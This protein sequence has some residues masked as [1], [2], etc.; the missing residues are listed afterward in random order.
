MTTPI[1]ATTRSL[2]HPSAPLREYYRDNIN[3]YFT[4][5]TCELS[6]SRE[7]QCVHSI[8]A[9]DRVFIPEQFATNHSRTRFVSGSCISMDPN[10][11]NNKNNNDY[12]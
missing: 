6:I 1:N 8:N 4:C 2:E 10:D 11:I 3:E 9:N 12:F 5:L 7:E